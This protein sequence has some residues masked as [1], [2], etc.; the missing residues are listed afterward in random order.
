[1]SIG[2]FF[3][4]SHYIAFKFWSAVA[5]VVGIGIASFFYTAAT[6]KDLR[7][8]IRDHQRPPKR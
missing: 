1:M 7:D 5:L 8:W 3:G 4:W 2:D 6:G